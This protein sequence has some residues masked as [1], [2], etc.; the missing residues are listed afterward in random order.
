[1]DILRF[2]NGYCGKSGL[3]YGGRPKRE[4]YLNGQLLINLGN[5]YSWKK[6]KYVK[7]AVKDL[8]E[9]L[10]SYRNWL[11]NRIVDACKSGKTEQLEAWEQDYL[12]KVLALCQAIQSGRVRG[13]VCWCLDLKDYVPVKGLADK[14]CHVQI[15]HGC[16]LTL[17]D[18]GL[19]PKEPVLDLQ[20][21]KPID[22]FDLW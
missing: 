13:L 20:H 15:L 17:I 8:A 6:S 22:V 2:K 1:M 18:L 14:R 9:S 16:C 3:V 4:N 7:G 12:T 21:A 5:P 19:V 10:S 11:W